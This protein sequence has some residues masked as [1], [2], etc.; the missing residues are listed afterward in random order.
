MGAC[1]QG[2][3]AKW[4]RNFGKR[5][6]SEGWARGPS[7]RGPGGR[8]EVLAARRPLAPLAAGGV[9]GRGES[10]PPGD[11]GRETAGSELARTKGI[12]LFN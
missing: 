2:K 5:I 3:S 7:R 12:R 6:G 10:G 4:I 11:L 9:S 8:R 1:G